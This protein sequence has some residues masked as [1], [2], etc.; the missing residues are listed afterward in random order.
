[1]RRNRNPVEFRL[2]SRGRVLPRRDSTSRPASCSEH[3][4]VPAKDDYP[5]RDRRTD[6]KP[7]LRSSAISSLTIAAAS[8][9]TSAI[10]ASVIA[11]R[12]RRDLFTASSR[13][14]LTAVSQPHQLANATGL[15][16]HLAPL[17]GRKIVESLRKVETGK[18]KMPSLPRPIARRGAHAT[19]T[20]KVGR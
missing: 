1:M 11:W 9:V 8:W 20:G 4:E 5:V 7:G 19:V 14:M 15:I 3:A 6:S 17:D 18:I 16:A 2:C 12:N 13:L 10:R